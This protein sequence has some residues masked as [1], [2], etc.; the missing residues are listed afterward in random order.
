[1]KQSAAATLAPATPARTLLGQPLGLATLFLTEVWE[2]FTYYG[3]QSLL[4]LF[5]VAPA[6]K[7]GLG[8]DDKSSASIY[9]LYV[10]G[11]YLLGLL[12]GWIADRLA[13]AQRAVIAGAILIAAGNTLLALGTTAIFF[14]GLLVIAMGV[15][16]LKPNVSALVAAL[17]PEGGA[18]R[19]AGFSIFYM[20]INIGGF[21]GPVVVPL[22]ATAFGWRFGF[23]LTALGMALGVVWFL[24]ARRFLGAAGTAVAPEQRASWT[25]VV[26]LLAGLTAV[27]LL[28]LGGALPIDGAR[29]ASSASWAFSLLA[30]AYFAYLLFFAGLTVTERKR[31]LVMVTL[32]LGSVTFWAGYFQQ[33]ASFN[34][35]AARYTDLDIFGWSMPPG[36]LQAAN[37]LFVIILAGAFAALWLAL[38]KRDRDPPSAAKFGV[39]LLLLGLG[40]LVMYFAAQ[41]VRAGHLVLPTWLLGTYFL[42]VCGEM[43][44]SPVG[45]SNMSKLVP[46]R[47]VGQAMGMWFLSLA[48]GGNLAGQL[49]GEYDASHLET[50][51]ALFLKI[52]WYGVIAGL[53][54][55][56]LT[57]LVKRLMAGVK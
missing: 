31:V 15:G 53:V 4:I 17:Y 30:V 39:G 55:L 37:S 51:P 22:V 47:F 54:M 40:F 21:L 13:G 8:L 6:A 7:G 1:M 20:G 18:R 46:P 26:L 32:F 33:G 41:H 5:M 2:R 19:D 27:V 38:G 9:G 34:L 49:T 16:F 42:H 52:F 44:L 25:P 48:L 14:V 3:I 12:G 36:I 50:L 23:A 43:C 56:A 45:L 35:F 57:P 28:A 11:T 10:G 24:W 29:L